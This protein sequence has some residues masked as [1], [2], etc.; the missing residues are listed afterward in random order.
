M[1]SKLK[2]KEERK[3]R[4][5]NLFIYSSAHRWHW[6]GLAHAA[7]PGCH[8]PSDPSAAPMLEPPLRCL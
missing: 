4:G 1:H 5:E 3:V 6:P 8:W 2:N 7:A